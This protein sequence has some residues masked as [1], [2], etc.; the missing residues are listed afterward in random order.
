MPTIGL[1]SVFPPMLPKKPALP[2]VKT[3]PSAA[4]VQYPC[5]GAAASAW[6]ELNA[7]GRTPAAASARAA[8]MTVRRRFQAVG[9]AIPVV[10]A[11]SISTPSCL[12]TRD[13]PP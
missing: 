8:V 5:M 11:A 4:A 13:G 7:P 10:G 12:G 6:R 9:D 2:N 1:V 3:P